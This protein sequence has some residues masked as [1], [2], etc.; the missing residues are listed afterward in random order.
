MGLA[1]T[2]FQPE[3]KINL[4][5][6]RIDGVVWNTQKLSIFGVGYNLGLRTNGLGLMV[7]SRTNKLTNN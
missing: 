7:C 5:A 2:Y 4:N 1:I 6:I 3:P